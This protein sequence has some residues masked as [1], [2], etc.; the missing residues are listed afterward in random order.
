MHPFL[1][2]AITAARKAGDIIIQSLDRID[3]L[4]ITDKGNHD[5]ATEIDQ[6]AEAKIIE[7]IRTAFPHH[8]IL[9]EESGFQAGDSHT[10][11]IDPLDGTTNFMH[12]FPHYAVSIA[13]QHENKLMH[14]VIYDP[15]DQDLFIAS[16]GEGAQLNE[17]RIRVSKR[18]DL[19]GA[20]LTTGFPFRDTALQQEYW[21]LFQN[22]HTQLSGY[23][24]TG[25]SALDLAYVAAGR[26]DCYW[27][28]V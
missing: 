9:A 2:I 27:D 4:A 28:W 3:S 15:L 14:G 12:G 8:G 6:Q 10:W 22:I 20:L 16:R 1:N 19:S 21:T 7:V 11:I 25:S 18:K 23:R 5:F 24:R 26:L 17:R 13:L